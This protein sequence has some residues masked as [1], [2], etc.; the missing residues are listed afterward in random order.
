MVTLN[1]MTTISEINNVS[2]LFINYFKSKGYVLCNQEPLIPIN[3]S[4]IAFTNA[5][6][7]PLK[8]YLNKSFKEPGFVVYQPCIRLHNLVDDDYTGKFTSFFRMVSILVHPSSDLINIYNDISE[9]VEKILSIPKD[10]IVVH[11]NNHVEDLVCEWKDNYSLIKGEFKNNFY[12][13]SYGVE[14]VKGRGVTF[15]INI[16]NQSRELGNFVEITR[17]RKVIGYEFGF[18]IESC[19]GVMN[20]HNNN[21][22]TLFNSDTDRKLHDMTSVRCVIQKSIKTYGNLKEMPSSTR[23]SIKKLDHELAY[24]ICEVKQGDCSYI[25]NIDW[26]LFEVEKEMVDEVA[27][28]LEAK[29]AQIK[30]NNA[31][32]D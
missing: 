19:V 3:D 23:S 28:Y 24:Y 29:V 21:F 17:N 13:W 4:T 1:C 6:I 5:T 32:L 12:E 11:Y 16:N 30:K 22:I 27:L 15:F 20:G 18:G 8:K 7:V 26:S 25:K 9:F 14:N 31:T 2:N 10:K